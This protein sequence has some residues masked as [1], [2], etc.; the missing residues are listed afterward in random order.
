M[1]K[2]IAFVVVIVLLFGLAGSIEEEPTQ[3]Y[4]VYN[5]MMGYDR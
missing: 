2:N 5:I 4:E 1:I 3:S